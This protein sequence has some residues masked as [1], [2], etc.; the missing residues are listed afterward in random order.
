MLACHAGGPVRFPAE[1]RFSSFFQPAG[2]TIFSQR[3]FHAAMHFSVKPRDGASPAGRTIFSSEIST[4]RCTLVSKP[5]RRSIGGSVVECSPATVGGPGSIPGRCTIFIFFQ[6]AGRTIFSSEISTL[7]STLVSKR[8]RRS[9]GG[10]VPAGRTIFTSEIST[11]RCTL[12]SKPSRRSIGGSVVECSPATRAARV[13]F[14]VDARFLS[15]SASWPNDFYQRNFHAAMHFSVETLETEH[16][17]FSGRMLACHAGGPGSIPGRCTIFI[18]F[19]PAG[20]TIFSSEISTL[21]CTLVSKP[22]DGA[23]VVQW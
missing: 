1:A 4:L 22:S 3:Y 23:S 7:R 16:R 19:Q 8:L 15:F 9:I 13:R 5:S 2:R 18:F 14:P 21:R 20:R 6:P 10:S 12:V 11:L 17:W